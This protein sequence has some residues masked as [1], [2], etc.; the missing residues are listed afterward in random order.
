VKEFSR[1]KNPFAETYLNEDNKLDVLNFINSKF[2]MQTLMGGY[3]VWTI[4]K[5]D[6]ARPNVTAGAT[7]TTIQD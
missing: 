3:G 2:K 1:M 7:T 6:E 4:T 5:G